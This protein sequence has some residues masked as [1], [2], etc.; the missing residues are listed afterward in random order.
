MQTAKPVRPLKKF[1]EK[2]L[3]LESDNEL[4]LKNIHGYEILRKRLEEAEEVSKD[5]DI[6]LAT[7]GDDCSLFCNTA[8]ACCLLCLLC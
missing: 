4:L 2:I 7:P 8:A 5:K 3:E 6:L 1:R